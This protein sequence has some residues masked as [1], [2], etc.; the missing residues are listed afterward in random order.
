MTK[1]K[2][3]PYNGRDYNIIKIIKGATKAGVEKDQK[4]EQNKYSSREKERPTK[5]RQCNFPI[6][7]TLELADYE[8]AG[9]CSWSCFDYCTTGPENE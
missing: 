7:E 4:K 9:F 1:K 5:C 2:P 8:Q 3:L 6:Q